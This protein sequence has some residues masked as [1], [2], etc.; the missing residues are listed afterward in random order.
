MKMDDNF[1][2]YSA[3]DSACMIEI[4][5]TIWNDIEADGFID[6]YRMTM[7]LME[8][9]TFMQTRGMRVSHDLLEQTKVDVLRK[10]AEYQ[11]ELNSLVGHPLNV[12]SPKECATYFYLDLGIPPYKNKTGSITCDD[13]AMQRLARGTA[14]RAGLREAKLVQDIRGLQKLYGT[15][16]NIKFDEDSRMRGSYNPRGTMFGRLSSSK[17]IFDTGMNFQNLPQQFKK[18][19][20]ADPEYFLLEIDKRQAEWVVV[21]YASGDANMISAIESGLDVHIHTA[22]LMFDADPDLVKYEAKKVGHSTSADEIYQIRQDDEILRKMCGNFPRTMSGR[23]CGKKSNHGLNYD[24]GYRNFALIN[25]VDEKEGK[26]IVDMY[27]R[28]YPGIRQWYDQVQRQLSKDRTLTNCFGR[29]VRFLGQWGDS[30]FKSAYSMIPQSTVVDG[31]NGGMVK[32]YNDKWIT[33]Y[34]NVDI[35]AQVHDSILLQVPLTLLSKPEACKKFLNLLHEYTSPEMTYNGRTFKIASDIK[36][37]LNWGEF[38]KDNKNGMQDV[39]DFQSIN[40]LLSTWE[41]IGGAGIN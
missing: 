3:L 35:L 37:G 10:A 38:N 11:E 22:S 6:T 5:N 4:H 31:L 39:T 36:V 32:I 20:T 15:Y 24:E 29:R 40:S 27:H 18:F 1:L 16:L 28:I 7:D 8:V 21:A 14:A 19:L 25:E 30:L 41:F 34:Q 17:T 2:T 33:Q 26:K 9:L 23:Q 12:N 13:L